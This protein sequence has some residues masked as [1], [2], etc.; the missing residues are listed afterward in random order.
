[1]KRFSTFACCLALLMPPLACQA[2]GAVHQAVSITP[3]FK[4]ADITQI[5]QA[6]AA[7]T[8]K[9]FILD[10]RVRAQVTMYSSAPMSPPA[11]YQAFLSILE[12]Y[13]F[14]AVP[15]GNNIEKIVPDADA[16]QMPGIDLPS[17][18]SSTSDE[19]VTQVIA[20]K[21]VS[22]AELVPILRP[23]IPQY[24]HL[25][26]YPPSNILIISDRASNVH[27]MMQI[28]QRI[29]Q[30]GNQ[31]VDVMPLQNASA[32]DVAR[33]IDSLYQGGA[34]VQEGRALKV[35]A[36]ERSNSILISGD[37]AQRLR[38]RA[39]VA[40][41][42]TPLQSG[43]NTQVVFLH[44]A[45]ASKLAPK[46]KEQMAELA[47]MS[48][49]NTGA[50]KNPQAAAEKNALVWADKENNALV[51]TAPP[52][53]MRTI[54]D[55]VNSL[56]RRRPE[57]LVQAI[58]AEVDVDKTDDL[59]INWAAYSQTNKVPLGGFSAPVGGTSIVDLI[60]AAQSGTSSLA[61][62]ATLLTGTTIG[63]GTIAAGGESFAAMIRALRSTGD[64]NI[65]STP[66]A[67]TMDNQ[68]ATLK[69]VD[70]VPFVTGQYSSQAGITNGT[71]TP[72]QTIQ[73][74]EVGTILK[75][76][77][78][79][80]A[81]GNSVML[82][83][84]VENSSVLATS[85]S[86]ASANPTT[87]KRSISTNVLIENGGI[88]V[89]GGLIDHEQ[90]RTHDSVPFLGSIPVLGLLFKSRNDSSKRDNLMIFI[91]PTILRDQSQAA[92]QTGNI[93]NYMLNQEGS[94]LPEQFPQLLRGEPAPRIPPLP[95]PP[96][97]G[98]LSAPSPLAPK[99]RSK[100][101]ETEA[102]PPGSGQSAPAHT[103]PAPAPQATPSSPPKSTSSAASQNG[104]NP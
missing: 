76:T 44:Y 72:F 96:P 32:A 67:V 64:T 20:V 75:V 81:E 78:T 83:L 70:E 29:D 42:D 66:S 104:G 22:A 49:G 33:T 62:A 59:G 45:D 99:A 41:L 27:R 68:Q 87:A 23:M 91:K 1:M 9:S 95:P 26:A 28:I 58:I 77:P 7:A 15:A 5:V 57:V 73:Q 36:D 10:P 3:N 69:V 82:K 30:I 16:R 102:S 51:I 98:T 12:V 50:G 6:V 40:E 43:G 4:D 17:H 55:I 13:G 93:Y 37:P 34:N 61:N 2:Q 103:E 31:D 84:S 88:V 46:L 89:L 35:V 56:D 90:D 8:G 60:G 52:K 94:I 53:V 100:K 25:A 18:V 14:I 97:P 54:L 74:Q 39:L 47:Q 80:S 63:V 11:F 19:I 24:G 71:V 21:N 101:P 38:I 48:A 65:V 85:L 79:I 92:Q 86:Q